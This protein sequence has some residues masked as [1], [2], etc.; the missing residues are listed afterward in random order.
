MPDR[1]FLTA[2]DLPAGPAPEPVPFP[3]FPDRLHAFVWRNWPLVPL[4]R[5]AR[6]VGASSEQIEAIGRAMG[7]PDPRPVTPDLCRRTYLT[8]IRRN[9]HLLPYEQLLDLL[10]WTAAEL[11]FA[12]RED[13]FLYIKLG[14][15]KPRC[16]PLRYQAPAETT[17]EHVRRIRR[18]VGSNCGRLL[19]RPGE[20]LFSFVGQLARK[21]RGYSSTPDRPNRF[22]PRFC[23]SYF[24]AH[25][26]P[27]ADPR[28]DPFP[29]GYLARLGAAGTDGVWL[30]SVLYRLSP[31]PWSPDR[32]DGFEARREQLGRLVERA[33]SNGL[34]IYLYLNEPRAMPLRFFDLHPDLRGVEEAGHASLCTGAPEVRAYLVEAVASL[35]AAVP[36]LAGL[37]TITASENLTNCWSHG[38]GDGC[39]RCGVRAPAEVVADVNRLIHAG[40]RQAGAATQL[41]AWDWGW[42]NEWAEAAIRGRPDDAALISVSEW[43]LPIDRGGVES[44][45]GEYSLSA[46]GPGPRA[47]RHWAIAR[48]RGLRAVAKIQA[49]V[50]WEL[51]AVPYLP[52]AA[53]AARH[54]ANL[55]AAGVDGLMLGWSLGGHPSPNLE[56]V[57][58]IGRAAG[59]HEVGGWT[60]ERVDE[61]TQPAGASRIAD[62][63]RAV[64]ERWYGN[65][66]AP[67]FVA[68]WETYGEA[69]SAFPFHVS[70]VYNAPLQLGPANLLWEAP[71]G[72]R[73]TMCGLPYDD[74]ERWRAVYPAAVFAAQLE[75]VAAG[76]ERAHG[77]LL[78]AYCEVQ[79]A[80]GQRTRAAA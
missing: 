66:L 3:H 53:T 40:I 1:P 16:V 7:L 47:L 9:W 2:A 11:A 12:L 57:A 18:L 29:D 71:T 55:R 68:A 74:L 27:L 25:G 72:Y 62:V 51:S 34:G 15:L 20:P 58:E 69:L 75:T 52:V 48:E 10:G 32:S 21:P 44:R 6:L 13:D 80:R 30:P 31:F 43:D 76:F 63:L 56:V 5:I 17:R 79:R 4:A 60:S 22:A 19:D 37:F 35:C 36:G 67:Q 64:A 41:L 77:A 23:S 50:T 59:A 8:V 54:A 14:S 70:V 45:V 24:G 65:E 46:V 39:P 26:D 42:A 61:W 38:R 49:N 73:A 33:R 28:T 78:D